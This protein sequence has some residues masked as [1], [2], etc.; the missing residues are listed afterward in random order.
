MATDDGSAS[1]IVSKHKE[2][3]D[4]HQAW[5]NLMTAYH[6]SKLS[7]WTARAVRAKLSRLTLNKGTSASNYINKFQTC[8][9]CDLE[10]INNGS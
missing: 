1:H 8:W 7:V 9:H 6:R 5:N 10:A 3:Q 4:G 2:R